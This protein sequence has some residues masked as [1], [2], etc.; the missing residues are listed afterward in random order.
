[1]TSSP[2]VGSLEAS[3]RVERPLA[4][5]PSSAH[6]TGARTSVTDRLALRLGLALVIW[7]RRNIERTPDRAAQRDAAVAGFVAELARRERELAAERRLLLEQ[8]RR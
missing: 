3:S 7:G 4:I 5:H 1:M 2:V 6:L 8:P